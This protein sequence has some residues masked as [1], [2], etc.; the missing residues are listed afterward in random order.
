MKHGVNSYEERLSGKGLIDFEH[1]RSH[2][3]DIRY[4]G[5]R[6]KTDIAFRGEVAMAIRNNSFFAASFYRYFGELQTAKSTN[7]G[8]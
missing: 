7:K 8:R 1:L 5:E 4:I 2:P 3:E 6:Y